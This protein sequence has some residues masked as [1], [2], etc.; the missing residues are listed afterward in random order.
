MKRRMT[1]NLIRSFHAEI[2]HRPLNEMEHISMCDD[3][4]FRHACRARSKQDMRRVIEVI[5]ALHW[6]GGVTNQVFTRKYGLE[7][8]TLNFAFSHPSDSYCR[9]PAL[10]GHQFIQQL[11]NRPS[12]YNEARLA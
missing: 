3:Y 1:R 7:I 10:F 4:A 9:A 8:V 12:R 6:R 2:L 5:L 11:I